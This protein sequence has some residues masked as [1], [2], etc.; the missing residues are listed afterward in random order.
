MPLYRF[1]DFNAGWYASRNAAFQ[2]AVVKATGVKLALDGDLIRYDSD[3]PGTTELAVRRLAGQLGM[4][5]GDIHRQLKKGIAAFEESDLY[6]KIFKIAEK[7]PGKHFRA[8]CCRI[9]LE[10]P[11]ITRN[12]TTAWFAKRVDD[13]RASCMARR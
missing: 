1:A 2:N 4:S 3:E 6:K 13:R 9:Q 8:R 5:D 12:L 11:K 7:R 10:S